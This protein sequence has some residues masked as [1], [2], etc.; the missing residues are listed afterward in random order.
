M[1][2]S[3]SCMSV[4]AMMG[5]SFHT[6]ATIFILV[7]L[8]VLGFVIG[9][10]MKHTLFLPTG[11]VFVGTV[12]RF[13]VGLVDT[14]IRGGTACCGCLICTFF[15]ICQF[16]CFTFANFFRIVTRLDCATA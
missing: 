1:H 5:V 3:S 11:F 8:L 7:T 16:A 10:V 6:E 4:A 12:L 9:L 2:S 15:L 13:V 14:I